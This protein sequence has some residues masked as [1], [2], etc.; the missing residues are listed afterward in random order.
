[1]K[2]RAARLSLVGA[3]LLS[4]LVSLAGPATRATAS[5][6][7]PSEILLRLAE[8]P[9]GFAPADDAGVA[10]LLPD[11]IARQAAASFRRE[12]AEP[13][14]GYVRQVVLAF[15]DRDATAYVPRFQSL[16]VKHQAYV[17]VSSDESA[18]RLVRT[19]GGETSAVAASAR[20]EML[21]V[22]TVAGPAGTVGPDDAVGLT[23]VAAARVPTVDLASASIGPDL[24]TRSMSNAQPGAGHLDIPN[25][26]DAANWPQPVE[27]LP[28]GPAISIVEARS[29]RPVGDP[30]LDVLSPIQNVARRPA[31]A[32]TDLLQFTKALGPLLSE[33]WSRALN[34]TDV[35][36]R[37]PQLVVVAAGESVLTGCPGPG[38]GRAPA[39]GLFYCPVDQTVYAY[40]PYMKDDLLE[41]ADWR[42]KDYV[43]ASYV[44]HEWG[45]HIQN[46]TNL[47]LVNAVLTINQIDH[48]PLI[49]RQREL[50]ADCYAGLF[51]RY[52]RDS[53]WLN[54]GDLEEAR[55]GMLRVGDFERE[56]F[57]HHGLPEQRREWFTRG[58][59][60]YTFRDCEPW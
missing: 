43:I 30:S 37:P 28:G 41:G 35:D 19:R 1:V 29:Q 16:M 12:S 11:N 32:N 14:L 45:H 17:L 4:F 7:P 18:F 50:Q 36:Y 42:A 9:E 53:G 33:F 47:L 13:G 56:S 39:D 34:M 46:L 55:Q 3:L 31:S 60:H 21:I 24:D 58:Y 15:D 25:Q 26:Q 52:A 23:R 2:H 57:D 20:G 54:A 59:V 51:T 6:L 49:S 40:E 22:T 5:H 48:A 38:G 8:L 27:T 10:S 44:A